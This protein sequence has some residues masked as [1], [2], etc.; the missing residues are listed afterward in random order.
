VKASQGTEEKPPSSRDRTT[1]VYL[2]LRELIVRGRIAPGAR[3]IETELSTR[4]EV[5]RTPVRSAL[6]RLTQEGYVMASGPGRQIRL[7]VTPLTEDDARELFGIVGELEGLAARNVAGTGETERSRIVEELA[8][9]DQALLETAGATPAVPDRIFDL[10]TTFHR[11]LVE[12]G[13]G[14]RLLAL[15]RSVKPQAD[16]YRRLYSTTQVARIRVSVEEHGAILQAVGGG[17]GQAAHDAVRAN[18]RNAADRLAET[19]RRS[20]ELGSW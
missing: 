5:S 8:G 10:F 14:T 20:G 13:A 16:R 17:D 11:R 6:Q 19:I 18:W 3:I 4:L 1:Q 15:H 9:L 7:S 2:Q 12:T